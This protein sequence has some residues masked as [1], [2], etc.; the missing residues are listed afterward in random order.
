MWE[1]VIRTAA[2]AVRR[3]ATGETGPRAGLR[4]PEGRRSGVTGQAAKVVPHGGTRHARMFGQGPNRPEGNIMRSRLLKAAVF[5]ALIGVAAL[6]AGA[7]PSTVSNL[8][9]QG[10]TR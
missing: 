5:A 6:A 10:R 3:G 8:L 9:R 1:A 2:T 4:V 7:A